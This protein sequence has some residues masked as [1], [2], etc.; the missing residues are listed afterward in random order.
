VLADVG[1]V[2]RQGGG[3]PSLVAP[4]EV[5][6]AP[7]ELLQGV[8]R[9]AAIA[10][11]FV[12]EPFELV[13]GTLLASGR[14][15]GLGRHEELL[16][17]FFAGRLLAD[18][19]LV[20]FFAV[21]LLDG[22]FFAVDFLAAEVPLLAFLAVRFDEL[23]LAGEVL[24]DFLAGD[25]LADDDFRADEDFRADDDFLAEGLREPLPSDPLLLLEDFFAVRRDRFP[26]EPLVEDFRA[27]ERRD[28]LP[29]PLLLLDDFFRLDPDSLS[30][31]SE[32]PS[33]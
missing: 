24:E 11:G 27:E 4:V 13:R 30:S 26:S 7:V 28:R 16:D 18:F 19:L 8:L 6:D 15:G 17:A 1:A 23:F 5:A 32:L 33:S 29:D 12:A 9:G 20:A 25:F 22:D 14:P 31:S 10:L 2:L 3:D 21:D